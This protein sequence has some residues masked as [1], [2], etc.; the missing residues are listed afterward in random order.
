MVKHFNNML[1]A[2]LHSRVLNQTLNP[3]IGWHFPGNGGY[4]GDIDKS[5]FAAM[6]F[7]EERNYSDWQNTESLKYALDYW[8][9]ANKDWF[10]FERLNRCILNFYT[11][12]MTMGWHTDH[13]KDNHFTLIYYINESDGGT[14]FKDIKIPHVANSGILL[15]SK[16]SH[17]NMES[18]VPRRISVAWVIVGELI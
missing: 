17:K 15:K 1:P 13:S 4:H 18:S 10:K 7:D 16:D 12:G 3:A 8:V 5:C 14:E 11:P 2:W 6:M 9:D